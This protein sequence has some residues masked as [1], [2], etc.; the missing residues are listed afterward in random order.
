MTKP[1]TPATPYHQAIDAI[2]LSKAEKDGL[3]SMFADP[4]AALLSQTPR[5]DETFAPRLRTVSRRRFASALA[6]AA[7]LALGAGSLAVASNITGL[8][9][10]DLVR[11]F[12]GTDDAFEETAETMGKSV[13]LSVT[14]DG[15]TMTLDSIAGDE[16]NLLCAFTLERVDDKPFEDGLDGA[17]DPKALELNIH[18]F[19]ISHELQ[20]VDRQFEAIDPTGRAVQYLCL[21]SSPEQAII[22]ETVTLYFQNFGSLRQ[23]TA[24]NEEESSA[25]DSALEAGLYAQGPWEFEL[26]LD[27]ENTTRQLPAGQS[28]TVDDM[29]AVID[30]LSISPLGVTC[31]FTF[32]G[33]EE[34]PYLDHS[35]TDAFFDLTVSLTMH[36]G[37]QVELRG[38]NDAANLRSSASIMSSSTGATGTL[39]APTRQII[40]PN[41]VAAVTIGELVVSAI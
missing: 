4:Q 21:W 24:W 9:P 15:I 22:G 38:K 36:D 23:I 13:G 40:D 27:Y 12:F 10:T 16:H 34:H 1:D 31:S 30:A 29:V 33:T 20:L 41:D 2:C 32:I 11:Q 28:V 39:Y 19:S 8:H 5:K 35:D 26:A 14:S 7:A 37:G 6:A 17:F 3:K 25:F 18:G